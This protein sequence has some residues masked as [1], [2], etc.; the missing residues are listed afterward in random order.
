MSRK[1]FVALAHEISLINDMNTRREAAV[2]VARA[3]DA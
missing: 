1:H 2:A 3:I